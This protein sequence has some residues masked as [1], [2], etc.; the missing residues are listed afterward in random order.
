MTLSISRRLSLPNI[1][2]QVTVNKWAQ[3]VTRSL[4]LILNYF[5]T[6]ISNSAVQNYKSLNFSMTDYNPKLGFKPGTTKTQVS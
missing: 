5:Q 3:N 2:W 6:L 1:L 4:E